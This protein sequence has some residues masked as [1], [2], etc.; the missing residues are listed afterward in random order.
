MA[1]RKQDALDYHAQGRPGKIEI[2]L[3]KPCKTQRDLSLAYTPGV[4][5][6]CLDIEKNPDDAFLYT[7]RGNLV[8]VVSN[9]TAV[10]GLGNIGALAG[11]PVMEG[12]GVLFKA[13][14]DVDVFDLE[15]E[16]PTPEECIKFCQMLEPTV[17][18]I[19]LED[20]KAPECFEVEERLKA[21]LKIPVF[22][23]DQHG[24]AIISGAALLNAAEVVGKKL[25]DLKCVF[26]GAGASALAS[27][28][29]Y[30]NLGVKRE[31]I[32][33]V[34]TKG[35]VH[36]E[37]TD[38]NKYKQ[39]YAH[40]LKCRTLEEALVGADVMVGL[41]VAGAVTGPMIAKMAPEPMI[42]AMANPTP[43]IMP[44]EIKAVRP[45]AIIAT[46]RSDYPNQVNNV[47]GFPFIFRGALDVGATA[48]NEE[49]KMA[50][51]RAL[52]ALAKE[53]VPDEVINAYGLDRLHFGPEYLI[54]KP[55]DPRVLLWEAPAVAEA[56]MK[57]GVARK[58][59]DLVEYRN[60]LEARLG[61]ARALMRGLIERAKRSPQRLVFPEGHDPRIIR[62]AR[63]IV[64]EGIGKP[65]LIGDP[66]EVRRIATEVDI[67]LD[68]VTVVDP[69]T[70]TDG[71]GY[72]D[73]LWKGR[74]RKGLTLAAARRLVEDPNYFGSMMVS[75]GGADAM[76]SGIDL[77]YPDKLYPL[78]QAIRAD[79]G[80][81]VSGVFMLVIEK[82]VYFVADTTVNH[83]PD[84]RTLATIAS[85]TARLVRKLGIT[86]RVALLSFS[87]FGSDRTPDTVKVAEAARLLHQEEPDLAVDGEMMAETALSPD[88]LKARYPFSRLQERANVLVCP[89]LSA[90][91]IAYQLLKRLGNAE[92]IGPI[93]VGM[94]KP[95]HIL[96]RDA[97]VQDVVNMAVIAAVDAQ[98]R[99]ARR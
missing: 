57:S 52:A 70:A 87:N 32:I 14:A 8:A 51:T 7:A 58:T 64:D 50:A 94:A 62:A 56:A 74:I 3:T 65:T 79:A 4:A 95:A 86:P 85:Q 72:A 78:L 96:Q 47:L 76:V 38:L 36:S 46:G 43:E 2:R 90:G 12:K 41:S 67:P 83:D 20:I 15:I 1:I 42:F 35:V 44:E 69:R 27:A 71:E 73:A 17:G 34:D 89:N 93:L 92:A 97:T 26:S 49:M 29:H 59:V 60:Q 68:G 61:H 18:G 39:P 24:T 54:P 6:P 66:V 48:I 23:D 81:V 40:K 80:G 91:N 63:Q 88:V 25:A 37:R 99:A 84:A 55:L 9:G 82:D 28:N 21:L 53:D 33:I 77:Y 30:V 45:D 98:E 75:T 13:F 22:H 31:N 10:L 5:E 16:A 11:K 19:N